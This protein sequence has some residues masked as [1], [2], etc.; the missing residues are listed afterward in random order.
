M[1]RSLAVLCLVAPP[2][3]AQDPVLVDPGVAQVEAIG[4]RSH[5]ARGR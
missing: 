2:A 3:A 1:L 4:T 5:P